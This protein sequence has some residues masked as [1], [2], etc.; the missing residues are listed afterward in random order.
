MTQ[1]TKSFSGLTITVRPSMATGISTNSIP[2]WAQSS[3]SLALMGREASE[4]FVSP[5]QNFWKPPPVPETP[6]VIRTL[7]RVRIPNS[8]ATASVIGKTVLEPSMAILPWRLYRS[9]SLLL[10]AAGLVGSPPSQAVKARPI[11]AIASRSRA[12]PGVKLPG[13]GLNLIPDF[14]TGSQVG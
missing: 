13:K 9:A 7:R 2:L 11:R 8:S 5:L 12:G 6:T 1:L 14:H 4:I 3:A 10:P